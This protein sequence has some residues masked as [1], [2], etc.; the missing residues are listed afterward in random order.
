MHRDVKPSNLLLAQPFFA[1]C[2]DGGRARARSLSLAEIC[3]A[4]WALV[5]LGSAAAL[6]SVLRWEWSPARPWAVLPRLR[7]EASGELPYETPSYSPPEV[8]LPPLFPTMLTAVSLWHDA[9]KTW[10]RKKLTHKSAN[11]HLA[12]LCCTSLQH[13]RGICGPWGARCLRPQ[14]GQSSLAALKTPPTRWPRMRRRR[15]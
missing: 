13:R 7:Q 15:A 3:A 10:A 11:R 2:A 9:H 1:R 6:V 4:R 8:W 14:P 5:D 12:R